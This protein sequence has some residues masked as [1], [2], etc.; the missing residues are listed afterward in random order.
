MS[1]PRGAYKC[2]KIQFGPFVRQDCQYDTWLI[3]LRFDNNTGS[4]LL[5]T[6]VGKHKHKW[7]QKI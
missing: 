3:Q 2:D 5:D 6:N 7:E 1:I 4:V